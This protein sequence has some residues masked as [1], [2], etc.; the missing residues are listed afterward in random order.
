MTERVTVVRVDENTVEFAPHR[1]AARWIRLELKKNMF[2]QELQQGQIGD[3]ETEDG[4]W[5]LD[6]VEG[7]AELVGSGA[8]GPASKLGFTVERHGVLFLPGYGVPAD[9]RDQAA[10]SLGIW[11]LPAGSAV[12]AH[13]DDPDI[14]GWAAAKAAK[15]AE[16]R[17]AAVERRR[18]GE[19]EAEKKRQRASPREHFV[20]P[21]TF[22]PFPGSPPP[23]SKP[24][25]HHT[26]R[27]PA[28]GATRY[29][30]TIAARLRAASPLLV[31]GVGP[32]VPGDV[33][34][35]APRTADGTHFVPG[36]SLHG[37]LRS[38][39]ET[40]AGSCL[41][42]FDDEF[43]PV[44][45]DVAS[46]ALRTGWQL[47]VVAEA[48][49][50]RPTRLIRCTETKWV[51]L[52]QLADAAG[53]TGTVSTGQR[54]TLAN[55]F[56]RENGREIYDR[57]A[58]VELDPE[59]EWIVLVTD[60]GARVPARGTH[61]CAVG[62]LPSKPQSFG[63]GDEAW[64][65]FLKAAEG[66]KQFTAGQPRPVL[67]DE[68]RRLVGG[69][70]LDDVLG[71]DTHRVFPGRGRWHRPRAW[72]HKDQV[73]WLGPTAGP[74]VTAIALSYLWR[75]AGLRAAGDRVLDG[76]KACHDPND[77]CPSCRV[78]G[79]A[80]TRLAG[81]GGADRRRAE[82]LSYRGHV[83]ILDA[84]R[85]VGG[86]LVEVDLPA[87]GAPKPG[88]GQF[89]LDDPDGEPGEKD[90]PRNRW[91]V[92]DRTTPRS[93]RGR[94]FY[95]NTD[96]DTDEARGRWKKH[97]AAGG[98]S[99]RAELAPKDSEWKVT[100]VVD[101]LTAAEIGGIVASLQPERLFLTR[102]QPLPYKATDPQ[103]RIHVG[104][105]KGVGLGSCSVEQLT[106][107]LQD[108]E[109][110]YLTDTVSQ[111]DPDELVAAFAAEHGERMDENWR[112]T[113]A[114]LHTDH[115]DSRVVSYPTVKP[116]RDDRGTPNGAE[117]FRSF[118]WFVATTGERLGREAKPFVPLPHVSH[119]AQGLPV[120]VPRE[121]I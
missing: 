112:F 18:A 63:L 47:G 12:Q 41:R 28:G 105:G 19:K 121:Q 111:A 118:A 39:H 30:G 29:Q 54:F 55:K 103:F 17:A 25:G 27:S 87:M 48:V 42:V 59:G 11:V 58:P 100:L 37:A 14:E 89:Y 6:L 56:I 51:G 21:Y 13:F 84:P 79:S 120:S 26:L 49:D 114:A 119:P 61:L 109:G 73:V 96:P 106:V 9:L 45:R 53:G 43:V 71:A 77:L 75:S 70:S 80:D 52:L 22:V 31:R 33:V 65:T 64:E 72:L 57:E 66:A 91:G 40:L 62:R 115:V 97:P 67:E 7:R 34:A 101:G 8:S 24:A 68:Q 83:R 20:N 36:S 108:A 15:K 46:T 76:M 116:W 5:L 4:E 3:L 35:R 110:R 82:Q 99:E 92:P 81:L 85:T 10:G 93:L 69:E 86:P 94:K 95:W 2:Q 90:K 32:R 74:F 50:G 113:A 98:T 16:D 117:S 1:A 60:D 102:P 78:F 107:T 44:Y 104:G 38:M 88:S 23:R